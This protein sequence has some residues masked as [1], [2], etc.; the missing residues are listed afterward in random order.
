MVGSRTSESGVV[1]HTY[2]PAG[3]LTFGSFQPDADGR[4]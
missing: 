3:P 1:V 2:Q 4:A